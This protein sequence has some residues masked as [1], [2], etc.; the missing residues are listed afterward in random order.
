MFPTR[1][2]IPLRVGEGEA[3]PQD[4]EGTKVHISV[5]LFSFFPSVAA[6]NSLPVLFAHVPSR[7][8]ACGLMDVGERLLSVEHGDGSV[9]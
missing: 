7:N 2:L 3:A 9:A 4:Q 8:D 1:T 6:D 5:Y